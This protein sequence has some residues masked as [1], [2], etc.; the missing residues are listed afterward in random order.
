[1]QNYDIYVFILCFIVFTLLTALSIVCISTITRLSV[2]LIRSGADDERILEEHRKKQKKKPNKALKVID[3]A[4]S[5]IVCLV[6][7]FV[8]I[9]SFMVSCTDSKTEN[10]SFPSLSLRVVRTSS[11]AQKNPKN[12]YLE[13]NGIN[14]HIQAFDLIRTEKLPDEMDLELYDIVVYETDGMLIVHRIVEIEEPNAAHP[15]CRYFRLQGDAVDSPDRFPVRYEQMRAI[16]RGMRIPFVGSFILF[17]QSPAGWLCIL[18]IVSAMVVS[19]ILENIIQKEKDKRLLLYMATPVE[20]PIPTPK[21]EH[22]AHVIIKKH[23]LTSNS[24]RVGEIN[25]GTLNEHYNSGETVDIHSLKHKKLIGRSCKRV[26]VLENGSLNKALTVYADG[27]S[28]KAIL[29]I[30]QAGGTIVKHP[31]SPHKVHHEH[32]GGDQV[33]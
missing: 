24:G 25:V 19:P 31:G 32:S 15:D 23:S 6:L 28:P 1:M 20:D 27:F 11:M 12:D 17:M 4:F 9:G 16:Y 18:L 7:V 29:K 2:R 26:K 33:G 21:T 10:P 30:T 14:N 5:S 3:Y 13:E 8:F 22:K